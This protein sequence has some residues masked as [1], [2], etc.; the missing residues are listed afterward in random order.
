MQAEKLW[1]HPLAVSGQLAQ[2]NPDASHDLKGSEPFSQMTA[3]I[4]MT[5]IAFKPLLVSSRLKTQQL[6]VNRFAKVRDQEHPVE[7]LVIG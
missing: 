7:L 4:Q 2:S 1:G 3:R 6:P 5:K